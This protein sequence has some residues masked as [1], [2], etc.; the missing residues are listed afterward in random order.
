M[1]KHTNR[2]LLAM[3][4]AEGDSVSVNS[5]GGA[6]LAFDEKRL[7][8]SYP[9]LSF[10]ISTHA[11]ESRILGCELSTIFGRHVRMSM[12]RSLAS[13]A[14]VV[15]AVNAGGEPSGRP[16]MTGGARAG[17]IA[18]VSAGHGGPVNSMGGA[19]GSVGRVD[20][21]DPII[22]NSPFAKVITPQLFEQMFPQGSSLYS[23]EDL[24]RATAIYPD[25]AAEGRDGA[26][27]EAA[28]FL[29]NVARE[30]FELQYTDEIT[31]GPYCQPS[32]ECP[33]ADGKSYFGRG[34]LQISWNYN[35]CAAGKDLG[36]PLL[37]YPELVS[38]DP[39]LRW[40]AGLWFW[41]TQTSGTGHT[42]HSAI[43][44]DGFGET[45]RIINGGI[46]CNGPT[47]PEAQA[48]VADRKNHYRKFTAIL[49]VSIGG[50]IDC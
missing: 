14:L 5:G 29:A 46:E 17:G 37:T 47:N 33:C 45:I 20:G 34:A 19:A 48:S 16:P 27:R 22:A 49:G 26:K 11:I 38:S 24:A 41:M 13:C 8:S 39:K 21:A 18:A 2:K 40:L 4:T 9:R 3:V 7:Y 43:A 35:Y 31:Q 44:S 15:F 50:P 30:S 28:A 42:P 10:R 23:Y 12:A 25:F 36:L 32:D 6:V 1:M